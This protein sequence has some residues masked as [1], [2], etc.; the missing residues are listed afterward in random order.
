MPM[1]QIRFFVVVVAYTMQIVFYVYYKFDLK[2]R[3]IYDLYANIA[4]PLLAITL[5]FAQANAQLEHE[6]NNGQANVLQEHDN[7]IDQ[8]NDQQEQ[9][10]DIEQAN[11]QQEQDNDI[12]QANVQQE[13]EDNDTQPNPQ[14]AQENNENSD[15]IQIFD[16]YLD[17]KLNMKFLC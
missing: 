4:L 12:D 6:N 13:Q 3:N 17:K 1:S 16:Y 9:D 5:N 15:D 2:N 7:N 8:A 11:V 10:N 14:Q